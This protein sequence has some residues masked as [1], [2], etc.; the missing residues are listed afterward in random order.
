MMSNSTD[1]NG[2]ATLFLTTLI[3]VLLPIIESPD[4]MAPIFLIS[5]L[6]DE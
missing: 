5:T 4:L 2:G 6:T 1:L 3:L